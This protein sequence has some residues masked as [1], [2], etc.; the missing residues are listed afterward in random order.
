M[1]LRNVNGELFTLV[2]WVAIRSKKAVNYEPR[3]LMC[4]VLTTIQLQLY[5]LTPVVVKQLKIVTAA[6]ISMTSATLQTQSRMAKKIKENNCTEYILPC[7][8]CM[9]MSST[10]EC[11]APSTKF[12]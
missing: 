11:K 10:S 3:A 9:C 4:H 2:V 7:A 5:K 8:I 1:S 6:R 12:F